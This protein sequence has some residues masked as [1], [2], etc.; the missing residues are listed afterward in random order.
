MG[1]VT[2]AETRA[3]ITD[4][5]A[6]LNPSATY[7]TG[8]KVHIQDFRATSAPT[9]SLVGGVALEGYATCAVQMKRLTRPW[10]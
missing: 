9:R 8:I 10:C 1:T 2:E 6:F 5:V 4:P 3:F 7:P